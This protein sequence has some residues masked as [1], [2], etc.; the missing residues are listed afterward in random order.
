MQTAQRN[1]LRLLQWMMVALLAL[2]LALFAFASTVSWFS[3]NETADRDHP[4]DRCDCEQDACSESPSS[5]AAVGPS[6][7]Y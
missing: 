4:H 5:G 2:P 6:R 1:S 3:V 7:H